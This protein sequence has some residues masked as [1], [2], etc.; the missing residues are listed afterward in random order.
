[1]DL[2]AIDERIR[3]ILKATSALAVSSETL[4]EHDSLY[5]AG[6]KSLAT[7]HLILALEDEF[8]LEFPA[9]M[10]HRDTFASLARIRESVSALA[11]RRDASADD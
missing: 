4:S 5:D 10:M 6:L 7:L 1:M 9:T 3:N 11:S 8:E 2:P